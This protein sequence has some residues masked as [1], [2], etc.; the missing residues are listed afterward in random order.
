[1]SLPCGDV[2]ERLSEFI[3]ADQIDELCDAI[4]EHLS[5]CRDCRVEVDTLRRTIVL[6]QADREMK[7][8]VAVS[9]RLQVALAQEYQRASGS[10]D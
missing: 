8:P 2:R 9:A 3:D 1:M 6:Y 4:E 7:M 5:H 10:P